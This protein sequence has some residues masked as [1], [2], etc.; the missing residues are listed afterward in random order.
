MPVPD[1]QSL[2]A[3]TLAALADGGD[4]S[5]AELRTIIAS[6]LGL[7]QEDLREKIP[8]GTPL[9][10]NRTHWAVTYM[11]QAGLLSAPSAAWSVS[12]TGDGK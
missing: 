10:A 3:P 8:S 7:T 6:R 1:Y 4:H 5:L 12:P 2:M 11:Y 9:F